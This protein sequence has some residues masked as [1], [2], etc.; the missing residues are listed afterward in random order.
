MGKKDKEKA[1]KEYVELKHVETKK[2]SVDK[3]SLSEMLSV[4][5]QYDEEK[6]QA[7]TLNNIDRVI[8]GAFQKKRMML[9]RLYII[10]NQ[11]RKQM[12]LELIT[13]NDIKESCDKMVQSGYFEYQAVEYDNRVNDVYILTEKG[14]EETI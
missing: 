10:T 3:N 14:Q 5:K 8:L 2:Q 9:E 12:G 6:S 13:K 7:T 4:K 1:A 11:G